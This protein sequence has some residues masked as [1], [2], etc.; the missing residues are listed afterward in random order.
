[1]R[2]IHL[3]AAGLIGLTLRVLSPAP[4]HAIPGSGA[5]TPVADTAFLLA[6]D[7]TVVPVERRRWRYSHRRPSRPYYAPYADYPAYRYGSYAYDCRCETYAVYPAY[8]RPYSYSHLG[9]YYYEEGRPAYLP[10]FYTP[11]ASYYYYW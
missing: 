7:L 10:G 3:I 8:E 2:K 4:R 5:F 1:M 9:R 11:P 6:A